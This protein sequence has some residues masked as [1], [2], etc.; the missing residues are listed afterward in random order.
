[1]DTVFFVASKLLGGVLQPET[2]IVAAFG[3]I[4]LAL[5]ARR[6]RAALRLSLASFATLLVLGIVPLGD[7]MLAPI[8]RSYPLTPELQEVHGIIVLGGGEDLRASARWGAV[9]LG[10]GAERYTAT[11]ALAR[12]YPE[13]RI[14]FTGGSGALRD[15]RGAP[16]TEADLAARFFA[17]Q[18]LDAERL[19]LERRARNTAENARFS[20]ALAGAAPE[21]TWVLVTSAFHMPRA[22]RSFTNAGWTGLVP[23]PVDHR[24][25]R[26]SDQLGW[27]LGRNLAQMAIALR[28]YVGLVVYRAT[29]R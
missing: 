28:E 13:A 27:G 26:F 7:L 2:W 6:Q 5:I 3:A 22:M 1:M 15:A 4:A 16:L 11:L 8:E 24:T 10:Q 18:G 23:Y 29:A 14:V 25:A 21:E 20:H 19:I 9:Q 17:D 12:A